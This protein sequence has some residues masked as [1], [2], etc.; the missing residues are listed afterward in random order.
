M[1]NT[2]RAE[3]IADLRLNH[4]YCPKESIL[5]AADML[6]ADGEA[7]SSTNL[8]LE[9]LIKIQYGPKAQQVAVPAG[10][11]LVPIEPTPAMSAAGFCVNEAEHDPA[12]VYRAMLAAAQGAKN[13]DLQANLPRYSRE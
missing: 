11:V 8:K 5:K 12:G 4:E 6:E 9:K 2:K 7:M 10:Y 13:E 1:S 3:L